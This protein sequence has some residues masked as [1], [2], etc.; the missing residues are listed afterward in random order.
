MR[1]ATKLSNMTGYKISHASGSAA[2]SGLSNYTGALGIP[3]F[4]YEVGRG[5][6]PLSENLIGDIFYRIAESI[7][8]L[9]TLI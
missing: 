4:T 8:I 1:V 5:K 9:P 6:N 2:Y 7:I 3:S